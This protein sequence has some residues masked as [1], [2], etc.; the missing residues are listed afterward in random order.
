MIRLV[1][2]DIYTYDT[3]DEGGMSNSTAPQLQLLGGG[4]L[5]QNMGGFIFNLSY[6]ELGCQDGRYTI[7]FSGVRLNFRSE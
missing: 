5:L 7:N 4:W 2:S 6:G 1:M 3:D